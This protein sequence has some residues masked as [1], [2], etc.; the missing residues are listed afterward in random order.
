MNAL[1]YVNELRRII[2]TFNNADKT[3]NHLNKIENFYYF[4]NI[5][6]VKQTKIVNVF[7]V[8]DVQ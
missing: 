1:D 4:K 6:Y 8:G 3:L 5:K 7:E 2:T